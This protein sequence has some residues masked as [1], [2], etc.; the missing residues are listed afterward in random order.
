MADTLS[1]KL[2]GP[3]VGV[4]CMTIYV[5]SPLMGLI[6]EAQDK[7]VW[8]EIWKIERIRGEITNFFPDSRS[9]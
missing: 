9:C 3:S 7:D 6:R 4:S 8:E 2:V 5:D 1:R